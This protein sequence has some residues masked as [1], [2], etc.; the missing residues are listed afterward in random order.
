MGQVVFVA[1]KLDP[2]KQK[3]YPFQPDVRAAAARSLHEGVL[4]FLDGALRTHLERR[5]LIHPMSAETR[6]SLLIGM[7]C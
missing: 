4:A 2:M 1:D 3:A 7:A 5:E 6:N